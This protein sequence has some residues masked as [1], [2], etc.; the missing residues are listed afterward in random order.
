MLMFV[1]CPFFTIVSVPWSWSPHQNCP[2]VII[3]YVG[4]FSA[5]NVNLVMCSHLS[6]GE[7]NVTSSP[8]VRHPAAI[9]SDLY[10]HFAL[11]NFTANPC[12]VPL[13]SLAQW[14]GPQPHEDL[15]YFHIG[16]RVSAHSLPSSDLT[17]F[18]HL[19][20]DLILGSMRN[21]SQRLD[22]A[23]AQPFL[24]WLS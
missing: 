3:F 16:H 10:P 12:G 19:T 23:M 17:V 22:P 4:Q 9:I 5:L 14:C 15:L 13:P 21:E 2:E 18:P 24:V 6:R 7:D 1:G 11:R 8:R 20:W